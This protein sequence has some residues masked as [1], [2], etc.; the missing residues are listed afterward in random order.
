MFEKHKLKKA[1]AKLELELIK[2]QLDDIESQKE[3]ERWEKMPL[4]RKNIEID[5]LRSEPAKEHS[6][7]Y[8]AIM[9]G[10]CT[11]LYGVLGF[12]AYIVAIP[13]PINTSLNYFFVRLIATMI[14]FT[15]IALYYVFKRG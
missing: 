8:S 6:V 13:V 5:K 14:I 2:K 12:I 1:K 4:W 3:Q 10:I 9:A 7:K 11:L 15:Y